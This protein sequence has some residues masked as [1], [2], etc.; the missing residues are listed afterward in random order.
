MPSSHTARAIPTTTLPS[1]LTL[2]TARPL[3]AAAGLAFAAVAAHGQ[4]DPLAEPFPALMTPP[5]LD[6]RIGFRAEG[7][8][9]DDLCGATV[10][11]AGDV[12]GDGVDDVI[13][14]APGTRRSPGGSDAA[15]AAYVVFGRPASGGDPFPA[16]VRLAD[17]DG[18]EG[19]RILGANGGDRFGV[20]VAPAGDVNGDGVDDLVIGAHQYAY[21]GPGTGAAYV[22]YG[23]STPAGAVFPATIDTAALSLDDGF[24]LQGA[25]ANDMAGVSVSGAGDLNGDGIDDVIVGA[26]DA[27]PR[28][29]G[30]R[31]G[32]AY[33]VFG[34]DASVLGPFPAVVRL[35]ELDG[36]DG[37]AIV[38]VGPFD[39]CGR[40]VSS[41]GD[42]NGDGID[43]V[44]IGAFF[45]GHSTRPGSYFGASYVVFG[46]DT[47]A[48]G[49]FPAVF[50][51]ADL[52]GTNGVRFEGVDDTD[53]SGNA[54]SGAGDVNGDGVDD[55][56]IG[57]ENVRREGRPVGSSYVVFGKDTAAAGPFAAIVQLSDLDGVTGVRLDG[58]GDDFS[59]G[60]SVSGAGDV[61]GDGV[62]D[63]LVGELGRYAQGSCSVVFGRKTSVT[64][65]FPRTFDLTE[66]DGNNGFR[67]S[68]TDGLDDTGFSVAA[69]GDVNGDGR[70][71]IIVG[72]PQLASVGS[73]L[74]GTSYVIYGRS[75]VACRADLDGDG[76]LT[77]FDF[78]AF[79]NLFDAGDPIADFDGDCDFT[80]FD[81]LAYQNAFD[82][83]CA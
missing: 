77:I 71:D 7:V 64:G 74:V 1:S 62:D 76:T 4:A 61:N 16:S 19:F 70:D 26:P 32:A 3:L 63:L 35:D 9:P 36:R 18:R 66:L 53:L 46:R 24:R 8:N 34:R 22:V 43:D 79:Q 52:D 68:G 14:G 75:P 11:A 17:L 12:N 56:I 67:F 44:V 55:I 48:A 10:A 69:A 25:D 38:G 2:L 47:A 39:R 27:Y 13:V 73:G 81:F 49:A 50:Q 6:G 41:A 60:F 30:E 21:P 58:G 83:G 33:V 28:P 31:P 82:A 45:A 72:G 40:S 78:L 80:I 57:A 29:Y 54:V 65:P 37:L 51:L 20:S 5:D 59:T 42:F 23:R 15:G